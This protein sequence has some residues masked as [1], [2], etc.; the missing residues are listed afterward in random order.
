MEHQAKRGYIPSDAKEFGES[1][2]PVLRRAAEEVYYLINRGYPITNVTRFVG[3]H[4][5][6]S[7][8]QR[9]ALARSISPEERIISRKVREVKDIAG[10]TIYLDKPVSNSRR[11]K[12]KIL[13]YAEDA[14]FDTEVVIEDAVDHELKQKELVAT[15]DAIIL[16]ECEQWFNLAGY[17]ISRRIGE[18]PY[19]ELFFEK[20]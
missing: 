1:S 9:L 16:D 6:L 15:G 14:H 18:Y 7:E 10:R 5:L 4:Y 19:I 2:L 8:R 20:E 11:L 12:Q 3:N 17:V 13:S